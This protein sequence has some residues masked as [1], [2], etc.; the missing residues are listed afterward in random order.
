[1]FRQIDVLHKIHLSSIFLLPIL[2]ISVIF[3]TFISGAV[4]L[5]GGP[6][7]DLSHLFVHF[8]FHFSSY[9]FVMKDLFRTCPR[10]FAL[11]E[12][13]KRARSFTRPCP[14]RLRRSLDC[15][16]AEVA[17]AALHPPPLPAFRAAAGD[18][19]A[20]PQIPVPQSLLSGNASVLRSIL[21]D[22]QLTSGCPA[23]RQ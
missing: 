9:F 2:L 19:Q 4:P 8:F 16:A 18:F 12:H 17:R 11:L 10:T 23:P 14:G 13:I 5:S 15:D 20:L 1:M 3:L 7:Q 6:V 22:R 21:H